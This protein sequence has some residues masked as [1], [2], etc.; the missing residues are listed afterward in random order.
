MNHKGHDILRIRG[1][2][3]RFADSDPK[4]EKQKNKKLKIEDS[5]PTNLNLSAIDRNEVET[6]NVLNRL[7]LDI[8]AGKI[9]ALIGGNGAGKSTLFNLISGMYHKNSFSG[10]IHFYPTN[11][12]SS[13]D[14]IL[15][16]SIAP[17]RITRLGIGR[18][19]QESHIFPGMTA[20]ENMMIADEIRYG[21]LPFTKI[22]RPTSV[23]KI[24]C[25]RRNEAEGIFQMLFG[26]H[27]DLWEKRNELA[28]SLSYGQQRLLGLARLFMS[29]YQLVLLDEPT[30]GVHPDLIQSIMCVVRKMVSEQKMSVFLIE[31]NMEVVEEVADFCSFMGQGK[32][33]KDGTPKDVLSNET[34]RKDYLGI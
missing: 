6:L 16:N 19:F 10:T 15:L 14:E 23:K 27:N 9:Y 34:V 22:F 29:N 1:L 24:E 26:D 28:G 25:N 21:E 13:T 8:P 32:I 12:D 30:A 7:D 18:M 20:L 11:G 3:I 17:H 31:H 33:I 4:K 2:T 5:I